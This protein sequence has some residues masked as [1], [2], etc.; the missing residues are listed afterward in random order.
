MAKLADFKV[1]TRAINDGSWERVD[2]ARYGD[3]EIRSRGFTDQFVDMQ[4]KML[5]KA[6]EPYGGNQEDIPNDVRRMINADLCR[7][8]LVL[9]VRNLT[10]DD[11]HAVTIEAF[12]TMLDDPAYAR[13]LRACFDAAA[14]VSTRSEAMAK[15]IAGNSPPA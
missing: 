9:D 11:G 13:L 4:A 6:A 3:L 5:R 1:D 7:G 14:K 10:D 12:H 15:A 2:E 8:V